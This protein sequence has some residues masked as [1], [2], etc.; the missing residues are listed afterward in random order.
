[1]VFDKQRLP[2][3]LTP[4]GFRTTTYASGKEGRSC[5]SPGAEPVTKV[6][7]AR[8]ERGMQCATRGLERSPPLLKKTRAAAPNFWA[9]RDRDAVPPHDVRRVAKRDAI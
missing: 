8:A 2:G 3:V 1:M 5:T 4:G 7:E 9:Q 6:R